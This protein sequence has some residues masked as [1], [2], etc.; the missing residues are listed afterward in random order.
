MN[1]HVE[2]PGRETAVS[3]LSCFGIASVPILAYVAV[4]EWATPGLYLF[5]GLGTY[6][7]L[8]GFALWQLIRAVQMDERLRKLGAAGVVVGL[9]ATIFL[10]LRPRAGCIEPGQCPSGLTLDPLQFALGMALTSLS[11]FLDV[12]RRA[13]FRRNG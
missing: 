12:R 8:G 11:L 1:L 4:W 5:L 3:V 2:L 6:L 13:N 10:G 7:L 9:A